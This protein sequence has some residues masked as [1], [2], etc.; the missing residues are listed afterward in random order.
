MASITSFHRN[1]YRLYEHYVGEPDSS[2]D[3]YGYWLF[4]MGYLV[5]AAG[6]LIFVVSYAG[7]TGSYVLIR[8][9]TVTAGTGATIGLFGIVLMLPVRK[10]GIQAS[11]VGLV[12][13]LVGVALFA[14][15]YP[16]DWR[17]YG[18]DYSVEVI[19]V[20]SIGI[21]IIGGVTALVPILTGERGMFVEEVGVT[22]DPPIL[23][24]DAL[25]AA[26]FAVFRD[27]SGD[28]TWNVLHL[29]ALAASDERAVTR[30][31]ATEAIERVKSRI[32]SA[33]LL[34]L[35]TSAFR[36]YEDRNGTWQWS[37]A[38]DDGS[39][40][41]TCAG[42]FPDRDATEESVSFL[43]DRGPD[44]DVIEIDGAAF[45]Y[46]TDRDLWYW[47]LIDDERTPL[48]RSDRGFASQDRAEEAAHEFA[49]RF[50][51]ARVLDVEHVGIELYERE[52]DW[53]W[54][55]VDGQD[56]PVADSTEAFDSRRDA[57]EAVEAMVPELES[58]SVVV[59]GEPAFEL[60]ES[61]STW[62]WRLID[63]TESVV[64]RTPGGD[65][66]HASAVEE[67]AAFAEHA[68]DADVVEIDEAEYEVYPSDDAP[69]VAADDDLPAPVEEATA[70]PD[71]GT[72]LEFDEA[73][74]AWN[75]RL[76]TEDREVVA[77]STEA[78]PDAETATEAIER[79]RQQASEAD[80]IEFEHAAFQVYEADSGEWRWRLIDE[81]G[82]VLADSGEEHTSRSE[83][84]EA[85]MTLKE[86]APEA[87]L[88]EIETAAFELFVNE[89]GEWGWRLIDEG[90]KL[91]AEDPATHP[92]RA[93]AKEAMD[94]L[95]EHLDSDIREMERAIFQP[96]ADDDW[97][98]RFVL[99]A[100]ET[101]AVSE[102]EYP[103]RD[104]LVED[105]PRVREVATAADRFTIGEVAVQL[106]GADEW[107][108][109]LID[110]DRE[111][112]AVSAESYPT[113]ERART[114]VEGLQAHVSEAPVFSIED[115]VVRLE[116]D[117][118]WGWTLVDRDREAIARS[119]ET[120]ASK[121]DAFE[122]IETV[123][124]LAPLAGRVDFDVASF[125]LVADDENAWRWRLLDEDGRVVAAGTETYP[126]TEAVR[127]ALEDVRV[128]IEA[129]SIIEI[130]EVSFELHA[131]DDGEGWVWQLIDEHGTTMAE[132]TQTY[133]TRTAA[134][135][136][137]NDVKAHAPEGWITFTE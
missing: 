133:E 117:D 105:V 74:P 118:G 129:A 132:S 54:R 21:G 3:V 71:G 123:Q 41:A 94:R 33:G 12:I 111:E 49:E 14:M 109:R 42:E 128:V 135:E 53:G 66:E 23:T 89:D 13:A 125:E 120:A 130:D 79:V 131:H 78:H 43:K 25:E 60:Y 110:R 101:V 22:E 113:R 102:L 72:T 52:A 114:I 126:S 68:T 46:E 56:D 64:A 76:V 107:R 7:D 20:Y 63:E 24:G 77:A 75:W 106:Y 96:Y 51:R 88:I 87:D 85:M 121:T 4:L 30:P 26:Q 29:E 82:N 104:E 134:R 18:N 122:T 127:E 59:A 39:I 34:E 69:A 45:T 17:G 8:V 28:W 1:L 84:A 86:E 91:V 6:V 65:G 136:A 100:G 124:Q 36:L 50:D 2:S 5:A 55:F 95:L 92:T 58:A 9:S 90:G 73:G 97:H 108:F 19:A 31:E 35:T 80:L 40:V 44:A 61:G 15:F 112:L 119:V 98:W 10:R 27:D 11:V 48:A 137:M 93:A 62:R 81:D 83:A 57:E 99:P 70:R 38:R 115:A 16:H 103:T 37:L 47:T 32:S 116:S 67:T